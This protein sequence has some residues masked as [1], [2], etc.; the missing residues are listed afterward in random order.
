MTP[1]L[2]VLIIEAGAELAKSLIAAFA[3]G[4]HTILQRRI[5]DILPAP[6]LTT[7]AKK[8]ADAEAEK[9]FGVAP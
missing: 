4:D 7:I 9:K 6:L 3:Q 5:Q 8:L 1:E 2:V